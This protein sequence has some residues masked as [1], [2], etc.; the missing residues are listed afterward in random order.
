MLIKQAS[1]ITS[2]RVWHSQ[3]VDLGFYPKS[4]IKLFRLLPEEAG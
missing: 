4:N 1:R 2:V 3:A